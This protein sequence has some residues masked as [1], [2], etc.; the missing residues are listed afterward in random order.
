MSGIETQ[1]K[2]NQIVG[3]RGFQ[4]IEYFQVWAG[5][6]GRELKVVSFFYLDA[7]ALEQ[8]FNVGRIG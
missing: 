3:L 5:G 8:R 4:I 2:Y 7:K 6:R 1:V